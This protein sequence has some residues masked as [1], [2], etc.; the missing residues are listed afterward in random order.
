MKQDIRANWEIG[1]W[2]S[3]RENPEGYR[4]FYCDENGVEL[5]WEQAVELDPTKKFKKVWK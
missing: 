4:K 1:K 2:H 5:T 3:K